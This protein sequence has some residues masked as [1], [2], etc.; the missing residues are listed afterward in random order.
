MRIDDENLIEAAKEVLGVHYLDS[1]EEFLDW[2]NENYYGE[3]SS[4]QEFARDFVASG[5]WHDV[6][7]ELECY[8]DYD[9]IGSDLSCD[10][11]MAD[12]IVFTVD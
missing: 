10:F 7:P 6:P 11:Y 12:G 8:L 9:L 1:D 5:C 4:W 2:A 3:A